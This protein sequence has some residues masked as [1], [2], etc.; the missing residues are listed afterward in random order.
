MRE[1]VIGRIASPPRCPSY[2]LHARAR[3]A[4]LEKFLSPI[5]DLADI[6]RGSLHFTHNYDCRTNRPGA[7]LSRQCDG[8]GQFRSR[9]SLSLLVVSSQNFPGRWPT[10][11]HARPN[12]NYYCVGKTF[13]TF[14]AVALLRSA[15]RSNCLA[16][17]A[18]TVCQSSYCTWWSIRLYTSFC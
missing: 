4:L 16:I 5:K 1:A 10:R 3:L 12:Y 17:I 15:L 2:A 6:L 11:R 8:R 7:L 9:I 18:A 13:P 14:P